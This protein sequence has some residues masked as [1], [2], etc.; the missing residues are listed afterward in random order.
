MDRREISHWM[1]EVMDHLGRGCDQWQASEGGSE[2]F[3]LQAIE[4]DLSELQR[5]CRA[6]RQVKSAAFQHARAA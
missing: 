4:R 5:I 3:A 1:R 2:Q 6:A